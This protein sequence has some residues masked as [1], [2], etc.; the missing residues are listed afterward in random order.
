MTRHLPDT[1]IDATAGELA[2]IGGTDAHGRAARADTRHEPQGLGHY[3]N[4][5]GL[6]GTVE[7]GRH[8]ATGEEYAPR[9]RRF[10]RLRFRP[11]SPLTV[12]GPHILTD[13]TDW[14][15]GQ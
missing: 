6:V 7:I 4:V 12:D 14:V 8:P 5:I 9:G 1:V 2:P 3:S 15:L 10:A 13:T 11:E